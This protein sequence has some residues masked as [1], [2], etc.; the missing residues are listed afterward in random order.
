MTACVLISEKPTWVIPFM[1]RKI[2][3]AISQ[4]KANTLPWVTKVS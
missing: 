3:N 4:K 1:V 2:S